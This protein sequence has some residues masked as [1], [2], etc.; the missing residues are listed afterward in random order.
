MFMIDISKV[1]VQMCLECLGLPT[2]LAER[3]RMVHTSIFQINKN[4]QYSLI[5]SHS[6]VSKNDFSLGSFR[7]Y[8]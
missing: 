1:H 8:F 4:C 7:I 6:T 3:E 2:D 5:F